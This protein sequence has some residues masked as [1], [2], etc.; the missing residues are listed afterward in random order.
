LLRGRHTSDLGFEVVTT[1][2][3]GAEVPNLGGA[4]I[5][6]PTRGGSTV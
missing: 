1:L 5:P 6:A 2:R 4:L 3:V